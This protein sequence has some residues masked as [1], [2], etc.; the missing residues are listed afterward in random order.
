MNKYT[1]ITMNT[2]TDNG[3]GY[4]DETNVH[5]TEAM[6]VDAAIERYESDEEAVLVVLA[7]H[8]DVQY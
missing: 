4:H 6:S 2:V 1:V 7:G 3:T 5:F 8:C